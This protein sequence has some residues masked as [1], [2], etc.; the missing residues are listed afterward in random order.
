MKYRELRK[1]YYAGEETYLKEYDSRFQSPDT[2]H[3][4]FH[5]G[6]HEAFF[7]E[8]TAVLRLNVEIERLDKQVMKLSMQLPEV[9][10][11]QYSVKCLIDEIILTNKIE[12]VH[13]SRR[14]IGDALEVLAKQSAEKEEHPRFLSLVNKY[15][16]LMIQEPVSLETCED[17]RKIYDEMLLD[18]VIEEDPES[19]PDGKLFRKSSATVYDATG[20]AI[21]QGLNPEDRIL[22]AMGEAL[23]FLNDDAVEP[24]YRVCL[25]HYLL[26]YIHPFYDGNGR[27]GRF[28]LSYCIS[29]MMEPLLAYRIS[30]T[31]KENRKEYYAAFEIC[32]DRLNRG[33]LTPFLLMQMEMIRSAFQDLKDSLESKLTLWKRYERLVPELP[34]AEGN[35]NQ[36]MLYSLL[37][38][39]ALFSESG[40]STKELMLQFDMTYNPVKKLID[41]VPENML[42]IRKKGN[43]KYYQMDLAVLDRI[44]LKRAENEIR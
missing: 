40:I 31:I 5:I 27:L 43:A 28:I 23:T 21:H 18:E 3:V 38:Q 44:L 34:G 8:N 4:K 14:E 12:G 39:A 42:I 13:S 2:V 25:F 22:E 36:C 11:K 32:N 24:I 30:E 6:E 20:K 10:K 9:A 17:I 7:V 37:I 1:Y 41:Q 19:A 29:E 26:E 33:D 35:E 16:K 15:L